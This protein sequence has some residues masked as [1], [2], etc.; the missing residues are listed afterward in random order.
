MAIVEMSRISIAVLKSD[1]RKLLHLLSTLGV[2]DISNLT[3]AEIEENYQSLL[4]KSDYGKEITDCDSDLKELKSAIDLLA[5][6]ANR[7]YNLFTQKKEYPREEYDAVLKQLPEK[8]ELFEA[9]IAQNARRA[10]LKNQKASVLAQLQSLALWRELPFG[11]DEEGTK[12]MLFTYGTLESRADLESLKAKFDAVSPANIFASVNQDDHYQ[13]C[14]LVYPKERAQDFGIC[15]KEVSWNRMNF[16]TLS[17]SV[18]ENIQKYKQMLNSIDKQQEEIEAYL[19][20]CAKNID[21]YEFLYDAILSERTLREADARAAYTGRTAFVTGWTPTQSAGTVKAVVERNLDAAVEITQPTEDDEYPILLNNP[22]VVQPFEAITEMYS[23]PSSRSHLDPNKV[24]AIFYFILFGM[25]V[26][27]AGYGLLVMIACGFFVWKFKPEGQMGKMMRLIGLGGLSTFLWGALFGSWFGDVI[28][29]LTNGAFDMPRW[30]NPMND[31]M[32]LLIVSFVVGALHIMAGMGMKGYMLIKSGH[33]WDAV[34]DIGSWYLVFI[35]IGMY[36]AGMALGGMIG[37]IGMYIALAGVALLILT[38]GRHEKNIIMK[39]FKGIAS[40]Y[41]IIGYFSDILSYSRLLAM[42]LSTAVV[43]S[44]VNT[45]GLLG[46]RGVV[47]MIVFALVFLVGHVFNMAINL[48]GAYVHTSRLQYVEF[49]GKFYEGGGTAFRPLK[50]T[51]KY[52]HVR[53]QEVK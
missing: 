21:E 18:E 17:G 26:S 15:L 8:R 24:L 16:G 28:P 50:I 3:T 31:P 4:E 10:A 39:L 5:K 14:Y 53:E 46:G 2:T 23:L 9:V 48:L 47:G 37:Q 45:L 42:G 35:G 44:V 38:Q 43:A 33:V 49:F 30:F 11:V 19:K 13:Y 6:Y 27:D 40:L 34:F 29:V 1:R 32:K 52:T 20:E 36:A 12:T 22:R 7:K 25:M 51:G 41:D